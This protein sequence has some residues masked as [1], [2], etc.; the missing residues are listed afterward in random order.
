[1]T[2]C[3]DKP[4]A[5]SG[6]ETRSPS[7]IVSP[8]AATPSLPTGLPT[9]DAAGASLAVP[10]A[11]VSI[12][13]SSPTAPEVTTPEDY[14]PIPPTQTRTPPAAL[15]WMNAPVLPTASETA[16]QIYRRGLELGNDPH[17]FSKV[18]DCQNITTYFLAN[19]ERRNYYDLGEHAYL[20]ETLDWFAGSFIR[21]S[22]AVKGGYNA[23][24]IL[25][26][27]RADPKQ[28]MKSE[29][30]IACEFRL[31][32][33]SI[34]LISLEEW[35]SRE[36]E[37]YEKYMRKII[38]YTIE[39]GVVPI[40]ATKADNLEGDHLINTTIARLAWE[41]DIPLW[42]FWGAVQVIP[43]QGLLEDGFHLTRSPNFFDFKINTM[44]SGWSTRNLT[45]LQVIDA[46]WRS[47]SDVQ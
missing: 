16:R 26:P 10:P 35:W 1:M 11:E 47:L 32:N 29:N 25:T 2:A 39:E 18:G 21:E 28:C 19:F 12:S 22:A 37:N 30:P 20:Q 34:A 38:E 31:H 15:D 23:A 9:G 27:L 46:V 33:P 41:Y 8:P 5:Q 43:S 24:A 44:P 14:I 40:I 4:L 7:S 3:D 42:N 6:S 45:A 17:A 36:P 13:E